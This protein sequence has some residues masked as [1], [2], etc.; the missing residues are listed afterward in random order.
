M[1][2]K[3]SIIPICNKL[4]N[5]NQELKNIFGSIPLETLPD[6]NLHN[7][8]WAL[9]NRQIA[10]NIET[11]QNNDEMYLMVSKFF[12]ATKTFPLTF[13]HVLDNG[14]VILTPVTPIGFLDILLEKLDYVKNKAITNQQ[15]HWRPNHFYNWS[16]RYAAMILMHKATNYLN[17]NQNDKNACY[18]R[19]Y[20]LLKTILVD[21]ENNIHHHR[22][23]KT[24]NLIL[25]ELILDH[26]YI[27]IG[28]NKEDM[29]NYAKK[30]TITTLK[31]VTN[32][33]QKRYNNALDFFFKLI[34]PTNYKVISKHGIKQKNTTGHTNT[35][36]IQTESNNHS[37]VRVQMK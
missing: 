1:D 6:K 15:S 26:K 20:N 4:M 3:K 33:N 36:Q 11:K 35:I 24:N 10:K 13:P 2:T 34:R 28:K 31:E 32:K 9:C 25:A 8:V 22:T 19:A 16:A 17:E 21:V 37:D 30:L 27:P 23:T 5:Q 18:Q 12:L 14:L 29:I 7:I